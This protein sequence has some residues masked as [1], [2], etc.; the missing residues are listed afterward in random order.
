MTTL[1]LDTLRALLVLLLALPLAAAIVVI[2]TQTEHRRREFRGLLALLAFRLHPGSRR[3][4]ITE[5][6]E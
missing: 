2:G 1:P 6:G 3:A 4:S 5:P